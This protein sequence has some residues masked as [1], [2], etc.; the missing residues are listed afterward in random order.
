[1]F[2]IYDYTNFP[3]VNVDISGNI[4]GDVGFQNFTSQWLNLYILKTDFELVFDTLNTGYINPLYCLYTALFIKSIKKLSPQY[5]K[6]SKIYIYNR[7][8]FKLAKIIFYIEKPVA[9]VELILINDHDSYT[10]E[11]F[12]P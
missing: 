4:N 11:Y 3:I 10:Y 9:P 7:Y 6:K 8:I 1:M 2:A 5:L 12:Y